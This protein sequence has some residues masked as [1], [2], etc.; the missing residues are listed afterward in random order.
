MDAAPLR[1]LLA[2]HVLCTA[3]FRTNLLANCKIYDGGACK[4]TGRQLG[5]SILYE[6]VKKGRNGQVDLLALHEEIDGIVLGDHALE[7][8]SSAMQHCVSPVGVHA[9]CHQEPP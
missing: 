7:H 8:L 6:R 2:G 9:C 1:L 5:K 3:S 4:Q